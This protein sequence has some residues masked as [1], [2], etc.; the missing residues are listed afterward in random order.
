MARKN[1]KA[2]A[3]TAPLPPVMVTVGDMENANII[4]IGWTGILSTIPPRTY[5]SVRPQRHSYAMLKRSGE[6]VINL[7]TAD[8][9]RVVDYVGI[10]TGAK[11]D[12]FKECGLTKTESKEVG[13]PTI[14]QCPLALE[15]RVVEVIPMGTHDVFIADI[16]SVSCDDSIIDETGKIRFDKAGLLAY[17]H[18]EYYALGEKVGK[19]GFSTKK[20]QQKKNTPKKN[21]DEKKV[22]TEPVSRKTDIQEDKKRPFYLDAPRGK[23]NK[24]FATGIAVLVGG[25]FI[26]VNSFI[27]FGS[28]LWGTATDGLYIASGVISILNEKKKA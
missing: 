8:Q 17:A 12:K 2:G 24:S 14:A 27:G 10:Y 5:I 19:F 9:A 15:C 11:V 1:F 16:V 6:F 26:L 7:T 23:S 18:G 13:A 25:V 28:I 20:P 22:K 4:T 21:T 3:L